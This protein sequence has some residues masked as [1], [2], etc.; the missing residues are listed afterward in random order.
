LNLAI[1]RI[2]DTTASHH[3]AHRQPGHPQ[4]G[5]GTVADQQEVLAGD[6]QRIRRSPF[7]ADGL[8]VNR[9]SIISTPA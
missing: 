6:V 2:K 3:A 9:A 8:A 7:L 4:L 1:V 5:I